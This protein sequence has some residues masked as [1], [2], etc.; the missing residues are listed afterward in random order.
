MVFDWGGLAGVTHAAVY[1]ESDEVALPNPS[2][3][4]KKRAADTLLDCGVVAGS[5]VG[6]HF[7][8]VR[9]AC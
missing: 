1:D 3:A 6:G 5:P 7:Y 9:I 4:W 2:E 8:I